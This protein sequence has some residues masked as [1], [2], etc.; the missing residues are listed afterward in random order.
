MEA[1]TPWILQDGLRWRHLLPPLRELGTVTSPAPASSWALEAGRLSACFCL[2]APSNT[3][4]SPSRLC[5]LLITKPTKTAPST[6]LCR[7]TW[8]PPTGN[9]SLSHVQGQA[10]LMAGGV[11]R[12]NK[13]RVSSEVK[14]Y[15]IRSVV[16]ELTSPWLS[17]TALS[18]A[19]IDADTISNSVFLTRSIDFSGK[20]EN[21]HRANSLLY[22]STKTEIL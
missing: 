9:E 6:A 18:P 22:I 15:R 3:H 11:N 19:G 7:H 17:D 5:L 8:L 10:F 2:S 14:E 1:R 20:M 16:P 4:R 21:G 13:V 12:L